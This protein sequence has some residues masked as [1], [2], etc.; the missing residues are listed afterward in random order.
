MT[1]S[2]ARQIADEIVDDHRA[3]P[4]T[5]REAIIKRLIKIDEC[6]GCPSVSEALNMG[7]G[8]YKP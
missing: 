8:T 4:I 2:R 5:M 6:N 3:N 1:E 7:N